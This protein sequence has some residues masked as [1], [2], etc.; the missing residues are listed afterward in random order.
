[1]GTV[2]LPEEL[3]SY[4][5]DHPD[6]FSDVLAHAFAKKRQ[7]VTKPTGT[8]YGM[9]KHRR[10]SDSGDDD[11]SPKRARMVLPDNFNEMLVGDVRGVIYD[12]LIEMMD[13]DEETLVAFLHLGLVSHAM[14]GETTLRLEQFWQRTDLIGPLCRNVIIY[15]D[16]PRVRDLYVNAL[17]RKAPAVYMAWK[18]L[19]RE[20]AWHDGLTQ[21]LALF[22]RMEKLNDIPYFIRSGRDP[23][24]IFAMLCPHLHLKY[25]T[26]K[27]LVLFKYS[28]SLITAFAADSDVA[29][30]ALD[31]FYVTNDVLQYVATCARL[32]ASPR[33]QFLDDLFALAIRTDR[34]EFICPK[35]FRFGNRNFMIPCSDHLLDAIL[36]H[37]RGDLRDRLRVIE[38]LLI[39]PALMH[40]EARL[41]K[42]RL[43]RALIRHGISLNVLQ[44]Y[45]AL[46]DE[47]RFF[48]TA[49]E[50]Q[51]TDVVA[52]FYSD[53]APRHFATAIDC[54]FRRPY[55]LVRAS[56]GSGQLTM[57]ETL[58]R[59]LM[60]PTDDIL[61]SLDNAIDFSLP[62]AL[63]SADLYD[64]LKM[65][66]P[67]TDLPRK[68]LLAVANL[69][70]KVATATTFDPEAWLI[71]IE[72]FEHLTDSLDDTVVRAKVV[73][74]VALG[75]DYGDSTFVRS[76]MRHFVPIYHMIQGREDLSSA[77]KDDMI[78]RIFCIVP[79]YTNDESLVDVHW[80]N[81]WAYF[82]SDIGLA[83]YESFYARMYPLSAE[84]RLLR[85][86]SYSMEPFRAVLFILRTPKPKDWLKKVLLSYNTYFHLL[87]SAAQAP[88]AAKFFI[89]NVKAYA[90]QSQGSYDE[91]IQDVDDTAE[92]AF[93]YDLATRD[94]AFFKRGVVQEEH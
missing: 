69:R 3:T 90:Q 77:T 14:R 54:L 4:L 20:P 37:G 92:I 26:I 28:P 81:F 80:A 93:V 76:V 57:Y 86:I 9:P 32:V 38:S 5:I 82:E 49:V 1:M 61:F 22:L 23:V 94:L 68:N 51:R 52:H 30:A 72:R 34:L 84:K 75:T 91:P 19:L 11:N 16:Q 88:A 64:R 66:I 74:A 29:T 13:S 6:L 10:D 40:R 56:S 46:A 67:L 45:P 63:V 55:D 73:L 8:T 41:I 2:I 50:W 58:L 48:D 24:F 87:P 89:E 65:T 83:F 60:P 47:H 33:I 44:M 7:V 27:N 85:F 71:P 31:D 17:E 36:Q 59:I 35:I 62:S 25:P 42:E 53:G 43:G 79:V 78:V 39:E 15:F 18:T 12:K 21:A 70:W